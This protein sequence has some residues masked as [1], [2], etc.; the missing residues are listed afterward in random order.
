MDEL[1]DDLDGLDARLDELLEDLAVDLQKL[2]VAEGLESDDTD[3]GTIFFCFCIFCF[4]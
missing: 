2:G 1:V 3:T 4:F